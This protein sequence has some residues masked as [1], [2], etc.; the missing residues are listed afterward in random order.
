MSL[1]AFT[2]Q[3]LYVILVCRLYT[4]LTM[5]LDVINSLYADNELISIFISHL[6]RLCWHVPTCPDLRHVRETITSH[7]REVIRRRANR[8]TQR[9]TH[10]GR[11]TGSVRHSRPRDTDTRRRMTLL[12]QIDDDFVF[13]T[14][15]KLLHSLRPTRLSHLFPF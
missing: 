5:Y 10:T 8:H 1:L 12:Q 3:R 11:H 2:L 15:R 9:R 13:P 6:C 4:M 14:G 7:S